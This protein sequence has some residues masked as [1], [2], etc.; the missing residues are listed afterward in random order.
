M[1]FSRW[2]AVCAVGALAGAVA[3]PVDA[4]AAPTASYEASIP[5]ADHGAIYDWRANGDKGIWVQSAHH[6]WFYGTLLGTCL[7]LDTAW[8]IGFVTDAGGEFDRWSSIVV[9]HQIRCQLTSFV[10]SAAPPAG[11]RTGLG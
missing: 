4:D 3:T 8:R 1:S 9:P 6:Q 11:R 2:K 7:G 5:F 10:P